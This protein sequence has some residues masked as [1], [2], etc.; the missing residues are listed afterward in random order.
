MTSNSNERIQST[1]DK[2]TISP[3]PKISYSWISS[4]IE[5]NKITE[6]C[7]SYIYSIIAFNTKLHA[8]MKPQNLKQNGWNNDMKHLIWSRFSFS[9]YLLYKR[10]FY[11]IIRMVLRK[12]KR[13]RR[14][15]IIRRPF[16]TC[17]L[18]LGR[19]M[20]HCEKKTKTCVHF[21]N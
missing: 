13:N 10:Q 7:S 18:K 11:S 16:D 21:T 2:T 3:G 14:K 17:L 19:I 20:R 5:N 15:Q 6:Q 12:T 1:S 8:H 4:I 9:I